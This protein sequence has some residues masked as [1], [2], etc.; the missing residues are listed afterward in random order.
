M[1]N[2]VKNLNHEILKTFKNNWHLIFLETTRCLCKEMKNENK[3]LSDM[4]R[5]PIF[6]Q[7]FNKKCQS[8][9]VSKDTVEGKDFMLADRSRKSDQYIVICHSKSQ[10]DVSHTRGEAIY[11]PA[12][13]PHG[14][15]ERFQKRILGTMLLLCDIFAQN[16]TSNA[17]VTWIGII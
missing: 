17:L 1:W 5:V 8:V 9:K 7:Q 10:K 2:G 13:Q 11:H 16:I 12:T 14:L 4:L 6:K 15:T 3:I